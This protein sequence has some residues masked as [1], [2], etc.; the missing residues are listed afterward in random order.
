MTEKKSND[1][2]EILDNLS[3]PY[4]CYGIKTTNGLSVW[5]DQW[6]NNG[7]DDRALDGTIM[8]INSQTTHVTL[9]VEGE[10]LDER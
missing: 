5:L 2:T 6:L 10:L 3:K 4:G 1:S 8:I 7:G 9:W